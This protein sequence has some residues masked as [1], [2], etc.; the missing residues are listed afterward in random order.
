MP[1]SEHKRCE[2]CGQCLVIRWCDYHGV[3]AC[4]VCGSPYRIYHYDG[5]IVNYCG[6]IDPTDEYCIL[7]VLPTYK[8]SVLSIPSDREHEDAGLILRLPHQGLTVR[9]L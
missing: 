5:S 3:A 1:E 9:H 6:N 8:L 7:P 2:I 4:V